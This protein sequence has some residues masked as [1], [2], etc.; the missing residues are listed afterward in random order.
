MIITKTPF[1]VS[2]FG[3]GTDYPA[4]YQKHGGAV[5]GFTINKYCYLSI[6][7]LDPYFDFKYRI[8]WSRIEDVNKISEIKH[9]AVRAALGWVDLK[10]GYEI[11]Y[12]GDLPARSGLG[13]SSSFAVGIMNALHAVQGLKLS[14]R[15]LADKAIFLEQDIL[16]DTVGCQD[17]IWA[18]YG[19]FNQITF[20]PQG[21]GEQ[22]NVINLLICGRKR[23]EESF[24]LF[25][26]GF[27][28]TAS[29]IAERLIAAIEDG[30]KVDTL[31]KIGNYCETARWIL[32]DREDPLKEIG[33]LLHESW[34]LKQGL[35]E[36]INTPAVNE[37]YE[38]GLDA[39]A[40]GGKLLGAGG[41]GFILFIV[42]PENQQN[43]RDRLYKL[44]EVPIKISDE[45]SKILVLE[46]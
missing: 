26:T 11:S 8:I 19:G 32:L 24:M 16:K 31:T 29:D 2:L 25:F 3:G 12:R 44:I 15:E 28:R 18:A 37:I 5:V 46:H 38:E 7:K 1:R 42:P 13:T 43:V 35:T 27:T 41:G 21:D 17:Q 22:Y 30:G 10:G 20:R 36:G 39:G 40:F 33:E 4:W 23:L 9:P 45:G 34:I 6:S 14:Q